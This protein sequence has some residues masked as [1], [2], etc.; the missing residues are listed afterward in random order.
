[1]KKSYLIQF[2][3][4]V[5]FFLSISAAAKE[6]IGVAVYDDEGG[7]G[8]GVE[9]I[10]KSLSDEDL[11]FI[12]KVDANDIRSGILNSFDVVVLAGGRGSKQAK[13]LEPSGADSIRQFVKR[14]GGYLGICAGAYLATVEYPWSLGILNA[15][16]IDREH[17]NRGEGFVDINLSAAGQKFF[18]VE[19][20][21]INVQYGQGPLLSPADSA[22]LPQ[23]KELASYA[24]EIAKNGAPE[25]IMMG[26]TA[27]AQSEYGSGRVV[28][29]SPHP[30]KNPQLRHMIA[31]IVRWLAH[32]GKSGES[33]PGD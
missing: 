17:W 18:G 10:V 27:I 31:T 33:T 21:T 29:V 2:V 8:V 7:G 20:E 32:E 3:F 16:V 6:R 22:D 12:R 4:L 24:S 9:N 15:V 19:D 30:E 1:M 13:S 23:Y 14:G 5:F 26:T 25:G 28:A 11:F